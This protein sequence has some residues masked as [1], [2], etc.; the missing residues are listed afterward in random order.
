[1]KW[2]TL[3]GAAIALRLALPVFGY[4]TTVLIGVTYCPATYTSTSTSVSSSAS[5]IST[6]SASTAP[7]IVPGE[8]IVLAFKVNDISQYLKADGSITNDSLQSTNY[9]ITQSGQLSAGNG[10][11][12]T[13]GEVPYQPF[14]VSPDSPGM[15]RA[16]R[17]FTQFLINLDDILEWINNAFAGR[18]ALFC[19]S[20]LT[21]IA[22]F[23]GVTPPGC[24]PIEL[25]AIPAA[26][27]N[28][29]SSS[30][31]TGLPQSTTSNMPSVS[32]LISQPSSNS[33]SSS[34][35]GSS[36]NSVVLVSTIQTPP[37]SS[38][39]TSGLS[40]SGSSS[41]AMGSTSN[42]LP[43][44]S[45]SVP[46]TSA[47]GTDYSAPTTTGTPN[48]FD[49]SPFD[50]TVNKDFLVL[51]DTDLPGNDLD[52]VPA[53]NIAECIAACTAYG[54]G[55]EG[56]CVAVEFDIL[57]NTNPCHLKYAI[58]TVSRG[59]NS[60]SQAAIV[61]NKPYAP[62]IVFSD[63][64]AKSSSSSNVVD[65]STTVGPPPPASMMSTTPNGA[66]LPTTSP[67]LPPVNPTTFISGFPAPSSMPQFS[68]SS[69]PEGAQSSTSAVLS[70][71]EGMTTSLAISSSPGA[72]SSH[73]LPSTMAASGNIQISS[74]GSNPL[75]S[76]P[77]LNP[78]SSSAFFKP[79]SSSPA[80]NHGSSSPIVN[81]AS[82]SPVIN[83]ASSSIGNSITRS[84]HSA[85]PIGSSPAANT[86][87]PAATSPAAG[88]S[89]SVTSPSVSTPAA[90]SEPGSSSPIATMRE[91]S[92]SSVLVAST[93]TT[94]PSQTTAASTSTNIGPYCTATPADPNANFCPTYNHQGL[95][96]NSDGYCYE[97]E[98]STSLQGTAIPESFVE[99]SSLRTC[100]SL[101][102]EYNVG[103]PYG[104]LGVN[105]L[106]SAGANANCILLATITG[107]SANATGD[108]ARLL[109]AGYPTPDDPV[110]TLTSSTTS[111]TATPPTTAP[112]N[113]ASSITMSAATTTSSATAACP[114]A[115]TAT[116]ATPLCPGASPGACYEYAYYNN[117]VD[118]E[119]ECSTQFTGSHNQQLLAFNL[120]DCIRQCQ[121]LNT[122]FTNSCVGITFIEG[123]VGQGTTN[124]CYPYSTITCATRGNAMYNSAR[125][126]YAGYP[127][128]TDY[129]STF[130]C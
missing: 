67:S 77:T 83:P 18:R 58:S 118:F 42:L 119:I 52:A 128:V 21:L 29:A 44:S 110:Y 95:N 34:G 103:L 125:M 99:V 39:P 93:L 69:G 115:P 46:S 37:V 22:T 106:F 78:A 59:A 90:T 74:P 30:S 121:Y 28:Q 13:S 112:I 8:P 33:G 40:A 81:S 104:C 124:N 10:Y 96:V 17:I 109:Y 65:G 117:P 116:D 3:T 61:V 111:R 70:V 107:T 79:A 82:S 62:V 114:A 98:C 14:A 91:S 1:M 15:K 92:S 25:G 64:A 73:Q 71:V 57:A 127:Q 20:D 87:P 26:E 49:R 84:S 86:S 66:V 23:N 54:P 35:A 63:A 85:T 38:N 53:S 16:P 97:I 7:S 130:S 56:T 76:S 9:S 113:P 100:I 50:G 2:R 31:T 4:G 120:N 32:T 51:C 72:G 11:V 75:S 105:Y 60:F 80:V 101:C 45:S 68:P 36:T 47:S 27:L 88:A 12:S 55:S 48:C 108:S 6:T 122:V 129:N 126:F 19:V 24:T 102:T 89:L 123:E 41:A 43:S 94:T 5:I